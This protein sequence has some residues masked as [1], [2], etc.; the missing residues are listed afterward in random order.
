MSTEVGVHITICS[1][2]DIDTTKETAVIDMDLC[3]FMRGEKEDLSDVFGGIYFVS[4][5]SKETDEDDSNPLYFP[6]MSPGVV[7][8]EHCFTLTIK[9]DMD[10]NNFPFDVQDLLL[11]FYQG[12]FEYTFVSA[13][14]FWETNAK[15]LYST[16][17]LCVPSALV[18]EEWELHSPLIHYEKS[19]PLETMSAFTQVTVSLRFLRKGRGYVIRYMLSM[20]AMSFCSL[21]IFIPKP[22]AEPA[23]MLGYEVGL[24]FAV[25]AF[26]LLTS[27]L[28]PM[29]TT[30]TILDQYGTFLFFFLMLTMLTISGVSWM[31][32]SS[33]INWDI[34]AIWLFA[35]WLIYHFYFVTITLIT[36]KRQT[37]LLNSTKKK[38]IQHNAYIIKGE[39][40]QGTAINNIEYESNNDE[41]KE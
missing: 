33:L 26:Q 18:N 10:F 14:K 8:G 32:D 41:S 37:E 3:L 22:A 4:A 25:V 16:P 17:L 30:I 1:I 9:F 11:S 15:S 31:D 36:V 27:S 21:L 2:H 38:V 7:G 24:L 29:S 12:E 39:N 35:I 19:D 23:D 5:I 34:H 13:A 6:G 28:V 20:M 40:T